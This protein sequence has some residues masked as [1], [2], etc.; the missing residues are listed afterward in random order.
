MIQNLGL[1]INEF[2]IEKLNILCENLAFLA[3]KYNLASLLNRKE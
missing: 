2:R 3:V 1:R